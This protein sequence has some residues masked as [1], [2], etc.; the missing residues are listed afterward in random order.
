MYRCSV[1]GYFSEQ[2]WHGEW[3]TNGV[4]HEFV[5]AQTSTPLHGPAAVPGFHP[6]LHYPHPAYQVYHPHNVHSVQPY[7]QLPYMSGPVVVTGGES[8]YT[9]QGQAS[10]THPPPV[11]TTHNNVDLTQSARGQLE[12][13]EAD[14]GNPSPGPCKSPVSQKG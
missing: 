10:P 5:L 8:R 12:R 13:E 2:S 3:H 1:F 11:S 4:P 9:T 7:H 14:G 6:T